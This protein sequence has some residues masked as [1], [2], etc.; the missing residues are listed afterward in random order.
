VDFYSI[1]SICSLYFS[2]SQQKSA[3]I[4][5][6][7]ERVRHIY[8]QIYSAGVVVLQR[9]LLFYMRMSCAMQSNLVIFVVTMCVV[10]VIWKYITTYNFDHLLMYIVS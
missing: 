1:I 8:T 6:I 9:L 2:V 5:I 3:A 10:C 7:C 4:A